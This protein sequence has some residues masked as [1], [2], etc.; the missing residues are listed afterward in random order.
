M[1][2]RFDKEKNFQE[3]LEFIRY[4]A[5]WVLRSENSVWSEQQ[6]KLIDSFMQSAKNFKISKEKY[7]EM[8]DRRDG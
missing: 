7:L 5:E 3:R 2:F 6:A 1:E 8:T 4:Y